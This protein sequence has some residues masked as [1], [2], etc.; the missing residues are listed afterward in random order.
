MKKETIYHLKTIFDCIEIESSLRN[1][2]F[3]LWGIVQFLKHLVAAL[4][5][6]GPGLL[7]GFFFGEMKFVFSEFSFKWRSN[8]FYESWDVQL[9]FDTLFNAFRY[10]VLPLGGTKVKNAC[11][12]KLAAFRKTSAVSSIFIQNFWKNLW[13]KIC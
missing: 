7:R 1:K 2:C 13:W 12:A 3:F 10:K 6:K 9:I 5:L 11:W 8:T 4:T